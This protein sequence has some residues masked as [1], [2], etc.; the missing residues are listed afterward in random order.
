M[1][2]YVVIQ[3]FLAG[4]GEPVV[5]RSRMR[6]LAVAVAGLEVQVAVAALGLHGD[7]ITLGSEALTVLMGVLFLVALV[8]PSFVQVF[9]IKREDVAFR[10]AIGDLVSARESRDVAERLL[11]HVCALVGAS[12]AALLAGDGMVLARYPSWVKGSPPDDWSKPVRGRGAVGFWCGRRSGPT[13]V[14]AVRISPYMRYFGREE[15]RKL[16]DLAGMVGVAIERCEMAEQVAF[17]A[18]HDGLTGLA[19]RTMFMERL[20]ESLRHVGRRRTSLSVMFID[21]DRFKLVNDRAD[22]SA[23]DLV[24]QEMASRLTAM[25]RGVDVVARFGGDEFVLFA[26]VDHER[27]AVE[28]AERIRQ[29]LSV[30]VA[31]EGVHLSVTASIGV[32]VT[33][34]A[35]CTAATLLREADNAMYEAKRGRPRPGF[36]LPDQRPG[37]GQPQVGAQRHPGRPAQ[38]RLNPSCAGDEQLGLG[39]RPGRRCRSRCG[40]QRSQRCHPDA[41]AGVTGRLGG[42]GIERR[43]SARR[44]AEHEDGHEGS[45]PPL[46][47]LRRIATRTSPVSN[48][49]RVHLLPT[50][51]GAPS[52]LTGPLGTRPIGLVVRTGA[53]PVPTRTLCD[54]RR[55]VRPTL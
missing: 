31:V 23:G 6:L 4:R 34:E 17:Q 39:R 35:D 54:L 22:H 33:S 5:A 28:M 32:V 19:N 43:G 38:R 49:R 50:C 11:P 30:P 44:A 46:P 16:D 20:D 18:S 36:V 53:D 37:G 15:L 7:R 2:S 8:L 10:R 55:I 42:S 41:V 51:A 14:L 25:T 1:F 48:N 12:K 47:D 3:L 40:R 24:L 13:T 27:D 45:T 52:S 9:V 26:E 29:G 21:L